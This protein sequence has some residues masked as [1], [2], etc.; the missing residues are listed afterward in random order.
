M[1]C[2]GPIQKLKRRVE[3]AVRL[4]ETGEAQERMQLTRR[5]SATA[6]AV[7]PCALRN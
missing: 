4:F 5:T 2:V 1:G 6:A 3:V 7:I